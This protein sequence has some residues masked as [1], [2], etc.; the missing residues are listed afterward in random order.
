MTTVF[1][2]APRAKLPIAVTS[3]YRAMTRPQSVFCE[4]RLYA[5]LLPF[6]LVISAISECL[7]MAEAG[8]SIKR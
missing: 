4:W 5:L 8:S 3:D 2:R 1:H 6:I 7:Q